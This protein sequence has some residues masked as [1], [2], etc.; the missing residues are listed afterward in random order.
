MISP[1]LNMSITGVM[2][3][4]RE[5]DADG[6]KSMVYGCRFRS[7]IA[8]WRAAWHTGS[9]GETNATFPFG[10]VQ[11][12]PWGMPTPNGP[13]GPTNYVAVVRQAQATALQLDGVFMAVAI[14][15]GAY[16]G[17]CCAGLSNCDVY[18]TLCIHPRWKQEVGRRLALGARRVAYGE[19]SLCAEGP[20][21]VSAVA[22]GILRKGDAAGDIAGLEVTV[23]FSVC[24]AA[25]T[26]TGIDARVGR[27]GDAGSS[28]VLRNSTGF[29]MLMDT[30]LWM[31]AD[32]AGNTSTSI[33]LVPKASLESVALA[34]NTT[35]TAVRYLWS[36]APCF[37]PHPSTV[38][39]HC[40][41]YGISA[42]PTPPFI[43]NVTA[44]VA[45]DCA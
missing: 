7:M 40:S 41:L 30:G 34:S 25:T 27:K 42:L 14:D 4:Q 33:T 3:Y 36:Q 29:E 24:G 26:R 13:V 9:G 35:V 22:T 21:A 16:Q 2:Y 17:G 12:A 15:L 23:T 39:G 1:L 45:M 32:V 38:P 20:L 28:I 8:S 31:P 37:H 6:D 11:L 43:L 18:P 10:F 5:S 44:S 19:T